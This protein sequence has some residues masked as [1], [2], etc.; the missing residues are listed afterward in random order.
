MG[1]YIPYSYVV[2][3][4][5]ELFAEQMR[6]LALP[7]N[8]TSIHIAKAYVY[9]LTQMQFASYMNL[10][11]DAGSV[12][13]DNA[14]IANDANMFVGFCGDLLKSINTAISDTLKDNGKFTDADYEKIVAAFEKKINE[15][16]RARRFFSAGTRWY[17][18][19]NYKYFM[20]MA[21][22]CVFVHIYDNGKRYYLTETSEKE[23][24][25]QMSVATMIK[26]AIRVYQCLSPTAGLRSTAYQRGALRPA[27]NIANGLSAE[28]K[29]DES[30]RA[31]YVMSGTS[32]ES[33]IDHVSN[34]ATVVERRYYPA[35]FN[36][37]KDAVT[38]FGSPMIADLDFNSILDFANPDRKIT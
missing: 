35:N 18:F 2:K 38:V 9:Y 11:S 17:F 21:G 16:D 20:D 27:Y 4:W 31:Y 36:D 6:G 32:G 24:T 30:N 26:D 5:T 7:V 33:D 23:V 10:M 8:L 3:P 14:N 37:M 19:M 34:V 25:K 12:L 13:A 29:L 15:M 28:R 22:G 1:G